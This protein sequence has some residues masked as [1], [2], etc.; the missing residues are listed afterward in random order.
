MQ[1][2]V[3]VEQGFVY[4]CSGIDKGPRDKQIAIG[5][6]YQKL[7]SFGRWVCLGLWL[8][9]EDKSGLLS[10]KK[11]GRGNRHVLNRLFKFLFGAMR[12]QEQRGFRPGYS[13][14]VA[15]SGL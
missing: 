15:R 1:G 9:G 11:E 2:S 12:L 4:I 14:S 7:L 8:Y 3:P 5:A 10:G 13:G 6:S